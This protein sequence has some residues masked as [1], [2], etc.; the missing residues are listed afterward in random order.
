MKAEF[1]SNRH[2]LARLSLNLE[3]LQNSARR[4]S[5]S[6]PGLGAWLGGPGWRVLPAHCIVKIVGVAKA[7]NHQQAS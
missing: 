7:N 1:A 6:F 4:E 3:R 5:D 2:R